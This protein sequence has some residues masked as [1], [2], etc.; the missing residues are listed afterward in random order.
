[1]TKIKADI[2][3]TGELFATLAFDKRQT[4]QTYKEF[5]QS[6]KKKTHTGGKTKEV[7]K[8]ASKYSNDTSIIIR[9]RQPEPQYSMTRP[10]PE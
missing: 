4:L 5:L 10:L 3:V 7:T 1:M 8:I 6:H 2:I 9:E